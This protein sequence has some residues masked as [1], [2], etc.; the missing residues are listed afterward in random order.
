MVFH[1]APSDD[2][3]MESANP[4]GTNRPRPLRRS[5]GTRLLAGVAG[6]LAEYFDLDVTLVRV[7][8]VALALVGGIGVP[9]YV[10]AWLLIPEEGC[11]EAVADDWL[12]HAFH[13]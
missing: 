11:D 3:D 4:T 12:R 9:L 8:L 1:A 7:A 6:G 13:R 2:R 5:V 10:A